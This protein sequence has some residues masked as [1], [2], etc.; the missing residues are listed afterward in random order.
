MKDSGKILM[1][2]TLSKVFEHLR[3]HRKQNGTHMLK[4]VR[5]GA[6]PSPLLTQNI[7]SHDYKH[8]S[9]GLDFSIFLDF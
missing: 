5:F 3:I 8:S 7:I 1:H 2:L 9:Q 4:E 6:T